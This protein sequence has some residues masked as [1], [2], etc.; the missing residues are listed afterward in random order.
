MKK[1]RHPF[2]TLYSALIFLFLYAPIIVLIIFSFNES[3][4]RGHWGGFSLKWY[5]ELFDN[6]MLMDALKTTLSLGVL[7]SAIAVIIG[8]AAALGMFYAGKRVRGLLMNISSLPMLNAEIVTGISLLLLF[9]FIG[10]K[11]GFVS[12]LL[13]HITFNIPYVI[14]SVMPKLNQLDKHTFEAALDLGATPFQAFYKV[15]LPEIAPGIVTGFILAF[16]MSIDDFV[17]SF[18]TTGADVNTLSVA[19]Y[20]MTRR[21]IKPEINA[22]STL[23]FLAVLTLLL[24]VNVRSGRDAA[25]REKSRR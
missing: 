7:S 4:S 19:I 20:S 22:L 18:F 13:A 25:K 1:K 21:G 5:Q 17:I 16:T 24:I 12:L 2:T 15:M 14:L 3:K 23:M 9:T 11:L 8:T 10:L 6:S